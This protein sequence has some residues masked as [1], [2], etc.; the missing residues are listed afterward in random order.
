MSLYDYGNTRL[1][2]RLSDLQTIEKLESFAD[3]TAID[4]L[5]S[6]LTKTP[7]KTSIEKALTFTHGY[8]CVNQALKIESAEILNDLMK[9]YQDREQE[10]IRMI[11]F[12]NDL[13]NIKV[14]F[15]GILHHY[16]LEQITESFSHMGTITEPVLQHLV[17]AENLE[18]AIN[19]MAVYQLPISRPLLQLRSIKKDLTS[20]DI[21]LAMEKWYFQEIHNLLKGSA[22]DV[23]L[24]RKFYEVEADIA[25]LNTVL[26]FVGSESGHEKIGDKVNEYLIEAGKIPFNR[27]MKLVNYTSAEEMTRSLFNTR[28]GSFLHIAVECFQSTGLLS[29]FENQMRMYLLTWLASLPRL[30]PL[31]VGVPMGYVALK[32][33]EIKNLRWIAKGIESGFE[34]SYIRENL[35]RIG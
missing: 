12:R 20:S 33:S 9:F 7:Y 21:D 8:E 11:F 3:L 23:Q 24:L 19:R 1:R 22:E 31:G 28:Y 6:A 29:E 18:D 35:E 25:N 10:M 17:K 2:A 32:R 27:M 26:R 16:P 13:Q 14:I 34:P 5:I 30:Y 4:S 15:R